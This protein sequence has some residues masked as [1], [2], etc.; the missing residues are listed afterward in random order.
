MNPIKIPKYCIKQST[1][2]IVIGKK[3]LNSFNFK[4]YKKY[5]KI[6]LANITEF[7]SFPCY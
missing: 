2:E 4:L 3:K 1:D 6:Y 7:W 5:T